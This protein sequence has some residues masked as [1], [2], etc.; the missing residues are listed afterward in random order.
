MATYNTGLS[1]DGPGLLLRDIA[2]GAD[3]QVTA[4]TAVISKVQP[5]I[6]LLQSIDY[7]LDLHALTAFNAT[8]SEAGQH[9]PYIFSSLPNTGM[10]TGLDMD[11]DGRFINAKDAQSFGAFSG[12]KG[13][14]IL[15][16]Y[17]IMTDDVQDYSDV[18]WKDIPASLLL[19][20]NEAQGLTSA[21][22]DIQ[23][24]SY[25]AHWVVPINVQSHT[26]TLLAFHA[27]P[28]VFD[29]P[30]DRNGRRNHDE[31]RFWQLYMDGAFD[32]PP[33]HTFVLLGDA[34]LDPVDSEGRKE[35]IRALLQDPRL[36]DPSP[37]RS[38]PVSAQ[39]GQ[40]GDPMLDT[41]HWPKLDSMR[42]DYILPS[43]D[44]QVLASGV[45]WPDDTTPNGQTAAIAS[46]HR[47]VW[48]DIALD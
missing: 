38:F 12:Q 36:Q 45:Y 44:L 8:L 26:L 47:L 13:M 21:I 15:S 46:R 24:L 30:E 35:A 23:R 16:R 6:L 32:T 20:I 27:S 10:Q 7:D 2:S 11:L 14:A 25:V 48:V 9:Y 39:T 37:H 3:P 5:D 17:P 31:L 40:R 1:R 29:G 43:S 18:L 19:D 34:N 28:P 41:V 22:R 33:E 42:V 4:L